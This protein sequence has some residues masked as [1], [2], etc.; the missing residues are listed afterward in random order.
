VFLTL[1]HLH[2]LTAGIIMLTATWIWL[3]E[4]DYPRQLARL[5]PMGYGLTLALFCV[6][7]TSVLGVNLSRE[8][9]RASR[10]QLLQPWVGETL[11]A[12]VALYGVFSLL[13]RYQL[14][15]S[16]RQFVA[17][18]V[19][20]LVICA[21]SLEVHGFTAG[22]LMLLLG[23]AGNNSVLMGLSII[24]L[25]LFQSSYY[26]FLD[27]TLLKKAAILCGFGLALLFIRW[28]LPLLVDEGD[29]ADA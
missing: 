21:L 6:E 10:D 13:R 29:N 18:M 16:Q 7:S 4:F 14:R 11:I 1:N 9:G 20:T 26:Y 2:Y 22:M 12:L 24:A 19:A 15:M 8:L 5:V 28:L 25:L 27:V 23:F 3:H 17:A